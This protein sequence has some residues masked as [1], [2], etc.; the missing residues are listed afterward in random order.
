MPQK[1]YSKYHS[2]CLSNL[3]GRSIQTLFRFLDSKRLFTDVHEIFGYEPKPHKFT[4]AQ[5]KLGT[6]TDR[7]T[8]SLDVHLQKTSWLLHILA[9]SNRP[10]YVLKLTQ[11]RSALSFC[12]VDLLNSLLYPISLAF[13]TAIKYPG[14]EQ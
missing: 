4:I 3:W 5:P 13:F 6:R 9:R 8:H 12:A 7:L 11:Q 10:S 2:L 14:H 1:H